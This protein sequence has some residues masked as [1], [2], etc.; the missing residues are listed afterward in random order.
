MEESRHEK[1]CVFVKAMDFSMEET[2]LVYI[3]NVMTCILNAV[4][5]VPAIIGNFLVL[6]AIW[7][8]QLKRSPSN[9]LLSTLAFADLQVGL[10]VQTS[11]V[12]YKLT[13]IFRAA[14]MS[15]YARFVNIV[16]GYAT[17]AVSL[18]TLTAIAIE[19][20]LALHL[21]LRYK[22]VITKRRILS[23][24]GSF[25]V[26]GF[27]VTS[28]YFLQRNAFGGIVIAS[29][30]FSIAI[31]S[32]A[33]I[34]IYKIVK[35]HEREIN[36]QRRVSVY[37]GEQI[38]LNMKKYQRSTFTMVIVFMLS[39]VCYVPYSIV[40]ITKLK[41]GFTVQ[42]KVAIDIF[43]TVVCINSSMNP[44]IYCWRM[45][46]I[47]QAVWAVVKRNTTAITPGQNEQSMMTFAPVAQ[48]RLRT[49]SV[50]KGTDRK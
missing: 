38:E 17:T 19:R 23:A 14:E 40:M 10:I 48:L 31:T 47:K 13:E 24:A 18:L 11:F 20:F 8:T 41:Y 15:C 32:V 7:K 30:L 25:W 36:S 1:A 45:R 29:E 28:L 34:K 50:E 21:H 12:A 33:Y 16:F 37:P 27:A 22:E 35:R 49:K 44:V 9:I 2:Q 3:S 43:S 39:F 26:I 6:F 46:E 4:F 42:V 5:A